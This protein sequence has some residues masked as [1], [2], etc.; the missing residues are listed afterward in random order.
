MHGVQI[1]MLITG[2][3]P[4]GPLFRKSSDPVKAESL[5]VV[6]LTMPVIR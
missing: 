6:Y 5:L 3:V 4:A 2:F 1:N